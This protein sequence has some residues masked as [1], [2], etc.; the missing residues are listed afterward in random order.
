MFVSLN[1][2]IQEAE[3]KDGKFEATAWTALIARHCIKKQKTPM[4]M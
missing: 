4:N 1:L 3:T 2:R